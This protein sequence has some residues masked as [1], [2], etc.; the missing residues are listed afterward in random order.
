MLMEVS[1][2]FLILHGNSK[3]EEATMSQSISIGK[4][5][6]KNAATHTVP[7]LSV[8]LTRLSKYLLWTEAIHPTANDNNV[9]IEVVLSEEQTCRL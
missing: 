2:N 4:V 7:L 8:W 1:G 3:L 5:P 9:P 6:T